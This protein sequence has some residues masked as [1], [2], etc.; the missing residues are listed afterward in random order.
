[1]VVLFVELPEFLMAHGHDLRGDSSGD[2]GTV[3]AGKEEL[4]EI[5]LG[6]GNAG[7]RA[8][9]LVVYDALNL[10]LRICV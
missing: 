8:L 2:I 5:I 4:F 7:Q 10:D 9:H 1:M 3:A 6:H